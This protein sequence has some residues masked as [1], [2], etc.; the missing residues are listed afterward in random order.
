MTLCWNKTAPMKRNHRKA[1][2]LW[3]DHTLQGVTN[4]RRE[5]H[6]RHSV[7][8]RSAWQSCLLIRKKILISDNEQPQANHNWCLIASVNHFRPRNRLTFQALHFIT[9]FDNKWVII[10][11]A[12]D[13]GSFWGGFDHCFLSGSKSTW[14]VWLM[15]IITVHLVCIYFV[16]WL[17]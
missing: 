11:Q 7:R 17:A 13:L 1:L 16:S 12:S 6:Y 5:C 2:C 4:Q 8:P 15:H 3:Y 9:W 14:F 10:T